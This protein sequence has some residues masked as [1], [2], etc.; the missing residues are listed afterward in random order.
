[1]KTKTN[2]MTTMKMMTKK[3][4]PNLQKENRANKDE[5]DQSNQHTHHE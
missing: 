3:E 2:R 1:M 4:A 5:N